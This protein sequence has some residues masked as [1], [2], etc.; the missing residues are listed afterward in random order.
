MKGSIICFIGSD[1]SGKSTLVDYVFSTGRQ[2]TKKI[3]KIYGR[4]RPVF[5]KYLMS[6]G[7]RFFLGQNEG[8]FSNYDRYLDKKKSFIKKN[9]ILSKTYYRL[10]IIEYCIQLFF[11]VSIPYLFGYMIISDRY[12]Y[13]TIINDFAVDLDL[14]YTEVNTLLRQFWSLIPTPD[15]TFLVYVSAEVAL[16]R[17][18]DI[19]SSRYLEIRNK[20]YENLNLENII[21]L[22]G[23]KN[24]NELTEI[25]YKELAKKRLT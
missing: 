4:H 13:D 25:V 6:I 17:K 14:S 19:P 10:V 24:I 22:D 12:V 18:Q 20:F 21:V 9:G 16:K 7:R 3:K 11:K 23:T 5:I 2:K 15:I 1:G 8:I